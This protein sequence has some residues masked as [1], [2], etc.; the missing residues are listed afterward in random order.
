MLDLVRLSPQRHFPVGGEDLYRQVALLAG[1][2]EGVELL[3]V[4][5]G[6]GVTLEYF[7]R[8]W[9]AQ[10]TGVEADPYLLAQAESHARSAGLGTDLSFQEAAPGDLP[11]RDETFDVVVGEVGLAARGDPRQ[12][13]R[14]MVR[15]TRQG[16]KVVLIQ[17]VWT[18]AVEEA[19]KEILSLHLGARPLM[20]V[21]LR[22]ALLEAGARDLHAEDWTNPRSGSRREGRRPFPDFS[23][24]FPLL[25]KLGI[26]RRSWKRWG[27][28]GVEA[29]FRRETEVHRLLT[30]ERILG[31]TLLLGVKSGAAPE[32]RVEGREARGHFPGEGEGEGALFP[33][34]GG[35]DLQTAGLPLFGGSGLDIAP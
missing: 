10:G 7:V 14:E 21:E 9:G 17:L 5:C 6:R 32:A 30:R 4:A 35:G 19:R 18:G 11:F 27:W 25:Q 20:T 13:I 22:R 16:G 1:L 26:L 12:V 23:E 8:E 34:E 31:L 33:E 29:L 3:D 24:L 2:K 28:S 15:V